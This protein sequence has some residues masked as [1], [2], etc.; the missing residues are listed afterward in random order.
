M[1]K[2]L[3]RTKGVQMQIAEV[4]SFADYL[5]ARNWTPRVKITLPN[6]LKT[7]FKQRRKIRIGTMSNL[8]TT[9]KGSWTAALNTVNCV[10]IT[11]KGSC[12]CLCLN[13][14]FPIKACNLLRSINDLISRV[15][16][17]QDNP[18]GAANWPFNYYEQVW[19]GGGSACGLIAAYSEG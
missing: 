13:G 5:G 19:K 12:I 2:S 18:A 7:L 4:F 14:I 9:Q 11:W 3:I 8:S 17:C 6:A 1:W 16:C 15:Q 10:C